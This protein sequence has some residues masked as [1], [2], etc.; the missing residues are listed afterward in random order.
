MIYP[1]NTMNHVLSNHDHNP[2]VMG[3]YE[4]TIWIHMGVYS[5]GFIHILLNQ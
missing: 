1:V 3:S 2:I 5:H 4:I